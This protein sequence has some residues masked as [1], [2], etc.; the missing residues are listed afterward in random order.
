MT[1]PSLDPV[2][3]EQAARACYDISERI[4]DKI[5]AT[6]E[7]VGI[8]ADWTGRTRSAVLTQVDNQKQI[9]VDLVRLLD[10]GS[11]AMG[12]LGYSWVDLDDTAAVGMEAAPPASSG[13]VPVTGTTPN[14]ISTEINFA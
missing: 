7:A 2:A 14:T 1:S 5:K 8:P 9:L 11:K 4:Q 3:A 13:A 10:E 6:A 12:R